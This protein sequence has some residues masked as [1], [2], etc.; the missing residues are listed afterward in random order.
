MRKILFILIC[1]LSTLAGELAAHNATN[2]SVRQAGKKIII[3]YNLDEPSLVDLRVTYE[4]PDTTAGSIT[5]IQKSFWLFRCHPDSANNFAVSGDVGEVNAGTWKRITWDV[6]EDCEHFIANNVRFTVEAHSMYTG[7]K[8][9]LLAEYGYAIIPQHSWGLMV[10]QIYKSVGWYVSGRTNYAFGLPQPAYN[11]SEG[12]LINGHQPFYSGVVKKSHYVANA[13]VVWDMSRNRWTHSMISLYA[14]VGYG[15][16]YSLWQTT[17]G[18][19]VK[20]LPTSYK[21]VSFQ[22]GLVGA[23][24]GFTMNVGVSTIAFQYA[25]IEA[26]IGWTFANKVKWNKENTTK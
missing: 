2:V 9:F 21:G 25:E 18:Q 4:E 10:G 19:W 20:Y 24:K 13:G 3:T 12:G 6:L 8:T 14:G 15:A 22:L 5:A 17:D 26:G 23:V 11:A 16:R 7:T 1:L